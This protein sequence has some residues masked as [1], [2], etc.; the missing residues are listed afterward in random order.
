MSSDL[1]PGQ[2]I[3]F[4]VACGHPK[5]A[6]QAMALAMSARLHGA[7]APFVLLSDCADADV[8]RWFDA[9]VEPVAGVE[10][11][12]QKVVALQKTAA[13]RVLFLDSDSLAVKNLDELFPLFAGKDFAAMGDWITNGA[14]WGDT[15]ANMQKIGSTK[16]ARMNGGM[17]YY[18]RTP[19]GQTVVDRSLEV[20]RDFDRLGLDRLAGKIHDEGCVS[21]A[22]STTGLGELIPDTAGYSLTPWTFAEVELDVPKG[23]FRAING[24]RGEVRAVHPY[25]YHSAMSGWDLRYW[26]QV[27]RVVSTIRRGEAMKFQSGRKMTVPQKLSRR[28]AKGI[29]TIYK[30]M[31]LRDF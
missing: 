20:S 23:I 25:V 31:F 28:I 18:E 19:N 29:A 9:V 15:V 17:L 27:R 12:L 22:M 6:K 10:P 7:M 3:L 8:R 26:K 24:Y 16:V 30:K 2:A 13:N 4:S 11:Y 21:P 5:Y 14:Y 1:F